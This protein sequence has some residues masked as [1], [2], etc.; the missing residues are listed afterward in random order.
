MVAFVQVAEVWTPKQ[1]QMAL[2]SGAYGPHKE[3]SDVSAKTRFD[4][5]EGLPGSVW[6]SQKPQVWDSLEESHFVRMAEARRASLNSGVG[7]PV[8]AG[9]RDVSAVVVLLCGS[10]ES[11]GGCIERWDVHPETGELCHAGGYYGKLDKF[12]SMSPR[13]RF[14]KG[15]GLPGITLDR[16]LPSIE[17]DTRSSGSFLRAEIAR[18]YGIEAGIGI[19][20][21]KNG[22]VAH[23]VVLLSAASTPLARAFEVWV[24]SHS[25]TLRL[26]QAFYTSG[27]E[28]FADASRNMR[29]KA[30]KG[31]AGKAYRT[32]LPQV[33]SSLTAPAFTRHEAA[34]AAGLEIG[35]SIPISD[36]KQVRAVAVL[37]N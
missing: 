11:T 5:G 7:I 26:E 20:I 23:V 6:S 10:P 34:K 30:G 22:E 28:G 2:Y 33:L 37:L 35:V 25:D 27:L 9:G 24:P 18:E 1:E 29:V 13:M 8:S 4:F 12:A 3:F 14:Q 32:E 17:A 36:G 15:H 19:P 31:L 21:Y 16:G